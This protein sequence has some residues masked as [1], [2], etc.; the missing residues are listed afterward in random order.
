VSDGTHD[1]GHTLRF[2]DLIE[3]GRIWQKIIESIRRQNPGHEEADL[4][5]H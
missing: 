2:L 4:I 1:H 3:R 5:P